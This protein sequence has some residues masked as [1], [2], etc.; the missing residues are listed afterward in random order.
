[1]KTLR[2]FQNYMTYFL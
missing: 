2:I 1:M